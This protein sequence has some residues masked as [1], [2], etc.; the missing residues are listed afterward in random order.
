MLL[1]S[2]I[3]LIIDK[4]TLF[5]EPINKYTMYYSQA[6]DKALSNF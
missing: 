4:L 1:I 5:H 2:I 3:F 6:V